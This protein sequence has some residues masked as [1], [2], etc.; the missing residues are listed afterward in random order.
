MSFVSFFRYY[1]EFVWVIPSPSPNTVLSPILL[2]CKIDTIFASISFAND[3]RRQW[4]ILSTYWRFLV[5]WSGADFPMSLHFCFTWNF[6]F[7]NFLFGLFHHLIS[8][9]EIEH[10]IGMIS[11]HWITLSRFKAID[12]IYVNMCFMKLLISQISKTGDLLKSIIYSIH[13]TFKFKIVITVGKD[14]YVVITT[15][16]IE[17]E[18][19]QNYH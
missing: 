2:L 11:A 19:V 13:T 3:K 18:F 5:K 10:E 6:I 4:H 9:T 17:L 15:F 14:S 12:T 8:V 16:L 1:H 7:A